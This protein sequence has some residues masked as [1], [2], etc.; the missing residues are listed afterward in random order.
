M[1]RISL[2]A[3]TVYT[4]IQSVNFGVVRP[5]I[6]REA[7]LPLPHT[8]VQN[9][10]F[11]RLSRLWHNLER[12]NGKAPPSSALSLQF[13]SCS[14][15]SLI[16]RS[17]AAFSQSTANEHIANSLKLA[18]VFSY[19]VSTRMIQPSWLRS[20]HWLL[21]ATN[22]YFNPSTPSDNDV[23]QRASKSQPKL[24]ADTKCIFIFTTSRPSAHS[25]EW[26]DTAVTGN[27][28]QGVPLFS[29]AI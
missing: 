20:V 29:I 2:R 28:N 26:A 3:A 24:D 23:H 6:Y 13:S 17:S 9:K 18:M 10:E 21:L 27:T 16:T 19:E 8:M 14:I 11:W 7:S 22:Q 4:A 1:P 12:H 5:H 15:F 25:T